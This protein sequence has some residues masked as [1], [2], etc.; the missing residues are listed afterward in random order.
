MIEEKS[1]VVTD[2][3]AIEPIVKQVIKDNPN[4]VER[5]KA[6]EKKLIGFFMGQ[7]MKALRGKGDATIINSILMKLLQN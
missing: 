6:G 1:S 3:T 5:F 4:E 2:N 7:C